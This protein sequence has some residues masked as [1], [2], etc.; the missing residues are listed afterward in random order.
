MTRLA[1]ILLAVAALAG[2]AAASPAEAAVVC[3]YDPAGRSG[4]YFKMLQDFAL[5]AKTWGADIEVRPYTDEETASKDYEAGRCDGVV[6]T[7]VRLQRFNR[8]PSTLEAIGALPTYDHLRYMVDAL[9]RYGNKG[10]VS[11]DNETVGF[12]PVGAAYLFVRD[13]N[14]DTVAELAGKRIATMDYDKAAPVMVQRVG[15]I[16]VAADLGSIGPKFNN[17]DVDACYVSA[18][19]YKPFELHRGLGDKGGVIRLPL[20]Q[21]TL[22]VLVRPSRFPAGFGDKARKYFASRFD[23]ALA[24]VKAAEAGIPAKYWIDVGSIEQFDE[25]FQSVRVALRDEHKAYDGI[26]LKVMR[27]HRCE[28]DPSRP[29]CAEQKE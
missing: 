29:E 22:Q 19:V 18:P 15:A 12:I 8:F 20:A 16:M 13:R 25:L 9:A 23:D 2:V 24:I 21:A 4:D 28:R 1:R 10:L 17:G 14:V 5:E 3:T 7:G 27:N 11:G 26:M 6:A